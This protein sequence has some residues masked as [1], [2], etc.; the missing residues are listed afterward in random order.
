MK[1]GTDHT[2]EIRRYSGDIALY[3]H[4]KC[5]FEYGCSEWEESGKVVVKYLYSYCPCCGAR[6]KWITDERKI[7]RELDYGDN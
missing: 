5:G 2:W 1:R 3:V 6:K 4:C 7:E